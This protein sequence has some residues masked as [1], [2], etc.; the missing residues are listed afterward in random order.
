[1][2]LAL[3]DCFLSAALDWGPLPPCR[4]LSPRSF[5]AT[6]AAAL[7]SPSRVPLSLPLFHVPRG[8]VLGPL[9]LLLSALPVG[10]H[11][12]SSGFMHHLFAHGLQSSSSAQNSLLRARLINPDSAW[13]LVRS[14]N[15][16]CLEDSQLPD[17]VVGA[18][19]AVV[20]KKSHVHRASVLLE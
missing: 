6:R 15:K 14:F 20:K 5:D 12:H 1:M 4:A 13:N 9:F 7:S 2:K 16:D 3:L 17:T 18:G 8:S 19:Y 10:D 11:V